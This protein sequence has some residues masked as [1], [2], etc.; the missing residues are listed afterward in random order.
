MY[1]LWWESF[2]YKYIPLTKNTNQVI[3]KIFPPHNTDKQWLSKARR[4]CFFIPFYQRSSLK[5]SFHSYWRCYHIFV[6]YI[7]G[8]YMTAYYRKKNLVIKGMI[9][10]AESL[11]YRTKRYLWSSY[12]VL[13][14]RTMHKWKETLFRTGGTITK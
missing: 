1:I 13:C 10:S 9:E 8:V 6:L 4:R 12:R 14:I 5:L 11:N 7:N 2:P 3:T